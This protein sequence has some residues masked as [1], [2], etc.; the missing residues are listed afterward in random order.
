MLRSVGRCLQRSACRLTPRT[1]STVLPNMAART[2][3]AASASGG[4]QIAA[5]SEENPNIDV[6]RY[7]HKNRTWTT[8]HVQYYSEALAIGFLELGLAPGDVVLSW[9]PE[10]FSEQVSAAILVKLYICC[11]L[12]ISLV[13]SVYLER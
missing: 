13:I 1:T 8:N 7:T 10:H 4:T 5:L 2:F 6:V 3:A 9:L 11:I 12:D